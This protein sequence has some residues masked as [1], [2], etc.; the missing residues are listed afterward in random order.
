MKKSQV[1]MISWTSPSASGYGLPISRVTRRE[2]DSLLASNRRPTSAMTRPRAGAGTA[3]QPFCAPRAARQ[4][5]TKPSASVEQ[6]LR[7]DVGEVRRVGRLQAAAGRVV[8][9]APVDERRGRAG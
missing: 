7:H 3:A 5:A 2:S 9:L 8:E 6:H 1:S 4:A